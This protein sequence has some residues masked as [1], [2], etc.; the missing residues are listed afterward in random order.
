MADARTLAELGMATPLAKEVAAQIGGGG[1]GAVRS[2]NGQ[3]GDIV[4][5]AADVGAVAVPET[6]PAYSETAADLAAALVAAGLMAP[7][8]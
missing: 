7:Q 6:P 3:S 5:T 2:V 1:G 4:L 8:V